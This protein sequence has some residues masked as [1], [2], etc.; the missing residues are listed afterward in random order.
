MQ[1]LIEVI[2]YLF[3]VM[4]LIFTSLTFFEVYNCKDGK[5]SEFILCN[6]K[7]IKDKSVQIVIEIRNLTKFEENAIL[8]K[9]EK[10]E[11]ENIK[12]IADGIEVIRYN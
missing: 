8:E 11:Y 4:G 10:G 5:E 9:I 1:N 2:I 3:A 7:S 6:K 12:D